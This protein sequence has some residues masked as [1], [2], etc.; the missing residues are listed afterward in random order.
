ML[1]NS[2]KIKD[3]FILMKSNTSKSSDDSKRVLRGHCFIQS[4]EFA[5]TKYEILKND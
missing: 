1:Y 5:S 2:A 4:P 3:S